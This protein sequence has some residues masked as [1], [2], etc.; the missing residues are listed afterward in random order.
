MQIRT[1][2][3]DDMPHCVAQI[4]NAFKLDPLLAE[5]HIKK[6]V[7]RV[8]EFTVA[9]LSECEF[10]IVDCY[11]RLGEGTSP[12][13]RAG[14]GVIEKIRLHKPMIPILGISSSREHAAV[15]SMLVAGANRFWHRDDEHEFQAAVMATCNDG[16]FV[17][18]TVAEV[19]MDIEKLDLPNASL[20]VRKRCHAIADLLADGVAR[21][22]L[23]N[24][25]VER[26][27][28]VRKRASIDKYLKTLYDAVGCGRSIE[29]LRA[30][31]RQMGLPNPP[32]SRPD[33]PK[34][35]PGK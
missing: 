14:P 28:P 20:V 3:V 26:G 2:L 18:S 12:T 6:V 10:V 34:V 24:K 31:L 13:V 25:L 35:K 15:R 7:S 32:A 8:G 21:L 4:Q 11:L 17:S 5:F 9:D 33:A 1:L 29:A 30:W 16:R 23:P 19:L 27:M 22:D